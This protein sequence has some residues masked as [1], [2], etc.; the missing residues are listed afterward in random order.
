MLGENFL[1]LPPK[2]KKTAALNRQNRRQ[3]QLLNI[4]SRS[5]SGGFSF[6]PLGS[7]IDLYFYETS[8]LVGMQYIKGPEIKRS[9]VCYAILSAFFIKS[10]AVT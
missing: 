2:C 7:M 8:I 6:L 4:D 9:N 10:A 1:L 3:E 5:A